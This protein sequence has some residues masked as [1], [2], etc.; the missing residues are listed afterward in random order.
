MLQ[1]WGK[2]ES[3]RCHVYRSMQ[4]WDACSD[5]SIWLDSDDI[6]AEG[7]ATMVENNVLQHALNQRME[8]LMNVD[9][10]RGIAATGISYRTCDDEDGYNKP[11][12]STTS[13]CTAVELSSGQNIYGKL[14]V[15]SDGPRSIVKKAAGFTE[16]GWQYDQGAVV[17]T[18]EVISAG[19]NETAWQ[20]F[21][22]TGPVALLPLS[23]THSSLVWSTA[24]S[25]A[26]RLVE[27]SPEEFIEE[28]NHAIN[29]PIESFQNRESNGVIGILE[30]G[31]HTAAKAVESVLLPSLPTEARPKLPPLVHGVAEGSR[32]WFPLSLAHADHYVRPRIALA[33]DAAH[34]VHPLAGQGLNLGIGDARELSRIVCR[35]HELGIDT[36]EIHALME[37]EKC[38]QR[39]V[40]PVMAAT[41]MFKR[42]FSTSNSAVAS[43]RGVGLLGT[44]ALQPLKNVI[45][46]AAMHN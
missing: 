10:I 45:V 26:K 18:L 12:S 35:Q 34:K 16:V 33:G 3:Q 1:V 13:S 9:I 14:V 22:P 27:L 4:V 24:R 7:M 37:Y 20:R 23:S 21:L 19:L 46:K 38:R 40:L 11:A 5:G 32:A 43:V 8:E 15:G 31:L 30:N 44:N 17:A 28:L 36:G 2:V 29:S 42:L 39:G 25:N 41:D 6:G